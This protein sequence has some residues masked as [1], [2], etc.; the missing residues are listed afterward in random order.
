MKMRAPFLLKAPFRWIGGLT[1]F[2]W[3]VGLALPAKRLPHQSNGALLPREGSSGNCQPDVCQRVTRNLVTPLGQECNLY[4]LCRW[5][6]PTNLP[7]AVQRREPGR[8]YQF[9]L[10]IDERA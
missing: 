8:C 1:C 7:V 10:G 5:Y 6:C 4:S 3:L 9:S 2:C